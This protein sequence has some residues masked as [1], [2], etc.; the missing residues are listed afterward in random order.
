MSAGAPEGATSPDALGL[1]EGIATTR[2]I[3]RYLPDPIPTED[4]ARILFAAT[5]APTGSNLQPFRFLVLRDGPT[6]RRA[7]SL[8]GECFRAH[9]AIQ[10][11][12]YGYDHAEPG[13]RAARMGETMQ[14]FVDHFE[15]APVIVLA[16]AEGEPDRPAAE[17]D[18]SQVF[19]AVQNLLLAARALGY[20]GTISMWHHDIEDELRATLN[21]PHDAYLF[22]TIPLGRP[23]G[24]HGAVRR[25]PLRELVFEDEWGKEADWA[26]DPAGTRYSGPS[27]RGPS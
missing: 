9:W 16:C 26:V 19:P 21:V 14:R 6:A 23:A 27:R 2:A 1:L 17:T 5:R 22:A 13:S 3:R 7:R 10:R 15:E 12:D 25:L 24:R 4:L 18:A 11:H 8:L 20:G